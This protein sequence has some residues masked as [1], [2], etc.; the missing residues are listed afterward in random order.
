[1]Q[2]DEKYGSAGAGI[3]LFLDDDGSRRVGTRHSRKKEPKELPG[4]VYKQH[5]DAGV[6]KKLFEKYRTAPAGDRLDF[7][8]S[9][10]R[11]VVLA[12]Q[13]MVLGG[14]LDEETRT[15]LRD[16]LVPKVSACPSS[17]VTAVC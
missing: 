14:K 11:N 3:M 10:Y 5:L 16:E 13:I 17:H 7:L 1:M 2:D 15:Y 6:S 12:T 4:E 9:E 8:N